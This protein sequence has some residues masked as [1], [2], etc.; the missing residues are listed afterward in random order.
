MLAQCIC[1]ITALQLHGDRKETM[2]AVWNSMTMDLKCHVLTCTICSVAF[3]LSGSNL[4]VSVCAK[5]L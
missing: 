5:S 3:T 1:K 4:L 2:L